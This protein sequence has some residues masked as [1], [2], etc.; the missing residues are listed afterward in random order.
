MDTGRRGEDISDDPHVILS[1]DCLKIVSE[2]LCH[3]VARNRHLARLDKA[4]NAH[5]ALHAVDDMHK[6]IHKEPLVYDTEHRDG[7][8]YQK[9]FCVWKRVTNV[10]VRGIIIKERY[11]DYLITSD[12]PPY[13]LNLLYAGGYSANYAAYLFSENNDVDGEKMASNMAVKVIAVA[14]E[15]KESMPLKP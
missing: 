8:Q 5:I 15:C 10:R 1:K 4:D 6:Y 9:R 13:P 3:E 7:A 11:A 12:V 14:N 2:V